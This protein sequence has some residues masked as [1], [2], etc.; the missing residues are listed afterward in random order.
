MWIDSHCHLDYFS[1]PKETI[2][3]AEKAGVKTIIANST[4]LEGLHKVLGLQRQ[5][6]NTVK[7]ALGYHPEHIVQDLKEQREKTMEEIVL[8][9]REAIAFG[10]IGLDFFEN[11]TAEQK[12]IQAG[13]FKEFIALSKQFNKP[14][15]VHARGSRAEV[16]QI[17]LEEKCER[18]LL[19]S[20]VAKE[21]QTKQ[22]LKTPFFVSVSS[23]VLKSAWIQDFAKKLPLEKMLLETDSPL[24]FSGEKCS[25]AWI[26]RI[27]EKVA[28]LKGIEVE[29]V[30]GETEQ[31][32]H[33]LFGK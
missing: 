20:F 31:N 27:A 10:E 29:K 33:K 21:A 2:E 25:P 28:E 22:L 26:P 14:L 24:E 30:E 1:N 18:V 5:F 11:T 19:H 32:F 16:L 3:E 13:I 9:A 8:H 4:N 15:I 6:P 12:E 7:A 17:L 23:G